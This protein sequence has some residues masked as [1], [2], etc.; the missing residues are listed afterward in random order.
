MTQDDADKLKSQVEAMSWTQLLALW[1]WLTLEIYRRT[2]KG[3]IYEHHH[4]PRYD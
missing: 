1:K 3:P 2:A 4:R